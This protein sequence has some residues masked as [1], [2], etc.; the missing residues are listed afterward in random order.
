MT[1]YIRFLQAISVQKRIILFDDRK[2]D[3]F[4]LG[5]A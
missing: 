1:K 3:K 5:K 4:L 2:T